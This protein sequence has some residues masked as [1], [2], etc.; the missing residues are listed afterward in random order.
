MDPGPASRRAVFTT[1]G[2]VAIAVLTVA[3]PGVTAILWDAI[4]AGNRNTYRI[5]Q[6]ERRMD[7]RDIER[8]VYVPRIEA[9]EQNIYLLCRESKNQICR[10]Y[11]GH[12][13][14]SP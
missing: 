13:G 10:I 1:A 4:I 2:Y 7:T 5:E 6:L 14:P 3:I 9:D 11:P 12:N 8:S